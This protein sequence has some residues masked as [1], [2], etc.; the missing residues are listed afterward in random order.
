MNCGLL[1]I[2]FVWGCNELLPLLA[3]AKGSFGFC[4]VI[5]LFLWIGDFEDP[6]PQ[7]THATPLQNKPTQHSLQN[8]ASLINETTPTY[9]AS[10]IFNHQNQHSACLWGTT[11]RR[12]H[13]SSDTLVLTLNCRWESNSVLILS[14]SSYLAVAVIC[15]YNTTAYILSWNWSKEE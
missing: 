3:K 11:P 4:A 12:L 14:S 9:S 7:P 8:R 6:Q 2:Y 10:S 1:F 15:N 5:S 13:G